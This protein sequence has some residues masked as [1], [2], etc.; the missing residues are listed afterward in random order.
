LS[1][2][3]G[4]PGRQD[5]DREPDIDPEGPERQPLAEKPT[6]RLAP[7]DPSDPELPDDEDNAT[8]P[9]DD[10]DASDRKE[11][12]REDRP[13]PDQRVAHVS[14]VDRQTSEVREHPILHRDCEAA[15]VTPES[16]H[17]MIDRD[18]PLGFESPEQFQRFREDLHDSLRGAG[19]RDAEVVLKGSAGTFWSE[20]PT[21]TFPTSVHEVRALAEAN[22][23]SPDIAEQRYRDAGYAA[24][25]VAQ[26][27]KLGWDIATNL[28]LTPERSDYDL[29]ISSDRLS[30]E[31]RRLQES[32]GLPDE[33]VVSPKGGHMRES[34]VLDA[35]KPDVGGSA[36]QDFKERWTDELGRDVNLAGFPGGGP[37]A[38]HPSARRDDDWVI[39]A[40]ERAE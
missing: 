18:R 31:V 3:D 5:A 16:V 37:P 7:I 6:D 20:N 39:I 29:Q 33:R 38:E 27:E 26:P 35:T 19:L 28:G 24:P 12:R 21:K 11:P 10:R 2:A 14:L 8:P 32:K 13:N 30:D 25:D 22:G 23:Q 34:A 36:L 17:A 40:R 4:A 9:A 15:G 1:P